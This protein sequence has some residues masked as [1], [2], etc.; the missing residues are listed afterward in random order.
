MFELA[1][2]IDVTVLPDVFGIPD[3]Y[4]RGDKAFIRSN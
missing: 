1:A 4:T 2:M 3:F